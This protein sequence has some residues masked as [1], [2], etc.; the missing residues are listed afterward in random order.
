MRISGY[1]L[2][3]LFFLSGCVPTMAS[4]EPRQTLSAAGPFDFNWQLS[5]DPEVAPVQVF[6]HSHQIWLQFNQMA[7]LPAIFGLKQGQSHALSYQRF[8]PYVVIEGQWQELLFQGGHLQA[9][10][11]HASL[12]Q[13]AQPGHIPPATTG[14]KTALAAQTEQLSAPSAPAPDVVSTAAHKTKT[15]SASSGLSLGP[16]ERTSAAD[17]PTAEENKP[18]KQTTRV[19]ALKNNKT[20]AKRFSVSPADDTLRQALQRWAQEAGWH[21]GDQHWGLEVDYPI[22]NTA[23]FD[24]AFSEAVGQLLDSVR[25]GTTPL[26]ACF[27]SNQVLRIISATQSC[28]PDRPSVRKES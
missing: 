22:V 2:G 1:F 7:Y 13:Q 23:Q 14:K 9:R 25:L 19:V 15:E 27:Y 8:D 28:H 12:A 26:R 6:S 11:R 17:L 10:A 18:A 4:I 20:S 5:G 24:G 3:A 21:F 16:L